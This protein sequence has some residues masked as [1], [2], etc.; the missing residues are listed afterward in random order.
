[1]GEVGGDKIREVKR[2]QAKESHP[3]CVDFTVGE[4]GDWSTSTVF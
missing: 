3:S 4:T 2:F 1:M